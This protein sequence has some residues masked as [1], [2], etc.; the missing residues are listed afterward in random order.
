MR[1]RNLCVEDPRMTTLRTPLDAATAVL[2]NPKLPAG[3]DERFVGFGVLG[4]PFANGHYLALRHFP[5]T[6]FSPGYRSVWYRD[7]DGLWTFYATTPGSAKLRPL[8]QLVG[9]L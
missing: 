8:L 5:A 6:S 3:N 2:Q 7:P 4:L 9:D 1:G